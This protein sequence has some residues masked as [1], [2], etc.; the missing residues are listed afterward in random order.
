MKKVLWASMVYKNDYKYI[1]NYLDNIYKGVLIP[2]HVLLVDSDY[3]REI[4]E[5]VKETGNSV[6]Y[7]S[8]KSDK[9]INLGFNP[10]FNY[11][12]KYG[13]ENNFDY[14]VTMTV[15]N[16]PD[17]HWLKN[18][19]HSISINDSCGMVTTVH[20]SRSKNT[21]HN[22]GHYFSPSGGLYDFA[23]GINSE[24]LRDIIK[25][26]DG[27]DSLSIWS[28]CSGG[29]LYNLEFLKLSVST[30]TENFE[31]FHH[32]GFKSYNCCIIGNILR[33]NNYSNI[34]VPDAVCYRDDTESTSTHPNT[35]G[36]LINQEINRIAHL[37]SFWPE[38]LKSEAIRRYNEESRV[39]SNIQEIDKSIVLTLAKNLTR[40]WAK[41]TDISEAL[42]KHLS[43][44]VQNRD[45]KRSLI[46][47]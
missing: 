42:K 5:I 25:I 17:K 44:F 1:A 45:I 34:I 14:L 16:E 18:V 24:K 46:N 37:Y 47:H 32:Y 6:E 41:Q 10:S 27:L 35:P 22:I 28:P 12:V 36:L 21:I 2:D 4:E 30:L 3:T 31:I 19:L 20:I 8:I 15:R 40:K 23:R 43:F 39:N 38:E 7:V 9:Y 26:I 13:I 33:S 29:A 11:A